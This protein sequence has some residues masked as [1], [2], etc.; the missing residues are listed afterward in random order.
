MAA[1][2][3]TK[4]TEADCQNV[5]WEVV[6]ITPTYRRSVGRGTHPVSGLPI[7]VMRTEHLEDEAIQALNAEERSSRDGK[8]WS[9][10]AGSELGG[11]IP[12]IRV[13]RTPINKFLA[14]I[15]PKMREGDTD[16]LRWFLNQERNQPFRTRSG[17]L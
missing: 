15:A 5:R 16:H 12:M 17:K 10:G 14:D 11:N 4:L 3:N 9:S 7:E 8:R 6:E 1:L 2:A 13:A